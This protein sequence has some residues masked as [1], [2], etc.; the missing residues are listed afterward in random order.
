MK[1]KNMMMPVRKY[2][3]NQC[4]S[5]NTYL[6]LVTAEQKNGTWTFLCPECK[7]LT[8]HIRTKL[9]FSFR[10]LFLFKPIFQFFFRCYKCGWKS[11][12][13]PALALE[14]SILIVFCAD[15]GAIVSQS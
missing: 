5:K 14:E 11:D 4:R 13:P 15:C 7:A 8:V 9:V 1:W 2:W 3:C 12:L 10:F 6:N